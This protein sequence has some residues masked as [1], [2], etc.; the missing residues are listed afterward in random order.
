MPYSNEAVIQKKQKHKTLYPGFQELGMVGSRGVGVTINDSMREVSVALKMFCV[1]CG[2][3]R[4]NLHIKGQHTHCTDVNC[5]VLIMYCS[6]VS[7]ALWA[8]WVIGIQNHA[9]VFTT[10][11]ESIIISK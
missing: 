8:I 7:C 10:S 1:D 3:S 4:V 2:V 9:T 6:C 5:L 11:C